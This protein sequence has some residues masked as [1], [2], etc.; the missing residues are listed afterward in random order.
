MLIHGDILVMRRE[1]IL[2]HRE[3]ADDALRGALPRG[4]ALPFA[5][6]LTFARPSR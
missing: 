6:L 2:G 4:A 1:R 3:A 5:V